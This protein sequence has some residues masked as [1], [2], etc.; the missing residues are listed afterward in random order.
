MMVIKLEQ[1]LD[2]Y[3]W[4]F[5]EKKITVLW[6]LFVCCDFDI[7]ITNLSFVIACPF[8]KPQP[9]TKAGTDRSAGRI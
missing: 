1:N 9:L 6:I 5:Q 4:S 8:P 7:E 2:L 3:L